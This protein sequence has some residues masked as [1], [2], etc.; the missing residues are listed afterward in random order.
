MRHRLL[1][2]RPYHEAGRVVEIPRSSID[3]IELV[4]LAKLGKAP[5]ESD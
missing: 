2:S 1:L 4:P 5:V 3:S